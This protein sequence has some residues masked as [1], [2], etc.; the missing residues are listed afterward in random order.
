[1]IDI[2][3][4]F[5]NVFFVLF[6]LIYPTSDYANYIDYVSFTIIVSSV[7]FRLIIILIKKNQAD[8]MRRFKENNDYGEEFM[9]QGYRKDSQV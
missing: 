9:K 6:T 7:V 5:L 8:M 2:F 1:M 4:D 3:I